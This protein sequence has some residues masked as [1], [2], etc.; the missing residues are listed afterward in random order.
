MSILPEGV[1]FENSIAVQPG[2]EEAYGWLSYDH[3]RAVSVSIS[4]LGQPVPV[5]IPVEDVYKAFSRA[6]P[7]LNVV[8][9]SRRKGDRQELILQ[10]DSSE[11]S[12]APSSVAR[13]TSGT[14][15]S[16]SQ[17]MRITAELRLSRVGLSLIQ[18][19][20]IP[21]E[22]IYCQVELVRVQLAKDEFGGQQLNLLVSEMQVDCQLPGRA[23]GSHTAKNS[24]RRNAEENDGLGGLWRT[25]KPAVLLRNCA[26]GD[27]SFLALS[28]KLGASSNDFVVNKAELA[29]D[30][31]DISVDDEVLNGLQTFFAA[32][33]DDENNSSGVTLQHIRRTAGKAILTD[34]VLPPVPMVVQ[35][36]SLLLSEVELRLWCLL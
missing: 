4:R 27:R 7:R 13:T 18:V 16:T 36:D 5:K 22:L 29:L 8:L 17:G 31:L 26:D 30:S 12:A 34:Y 35:V 3:R 9:I 1:E 10:D 2:S 11:S 19:T 20:P 21:R 32:A 23:D 15:L 28:M 24:G 6:I 14:V 25:A 33:V